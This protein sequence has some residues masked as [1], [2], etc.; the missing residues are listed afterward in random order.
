MAQAF[1]GLVR[2]FL[3]GGEK[4]ID[5][6]RDAIREAVGNHASLLTDLIPELVRLIGPQAPVAALS[7][8]ETRLRFQLVF[9]RFVNVFARPEHPLV[10]FVDDLQARS[11]DLDG[12]ISHH[13]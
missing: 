7:P 5:H 11:G 13:S 2:Q 12:P 8:A 6:W 1:Q 4:D 10:I 3:R 9:Q